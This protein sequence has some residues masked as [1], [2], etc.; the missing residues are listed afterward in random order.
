MKR[1]RTGNILELYENNMSMPVQMEVNN[2][3]Y[4]FGLQGKGN[5]IFSMCL[6]VT[7]VFSDI[8]N[9]IK[10]KVKSKY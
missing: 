10:S 8:L 3:T 6:L 9:C 7:G 4:A 2:T 5:R 1:K